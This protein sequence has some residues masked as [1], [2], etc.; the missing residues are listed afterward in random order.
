MENIPLRLRTTSE[1]NVGSWYQ[2]KS[3]EPKNKQALSLENA[4]VA[5]TFL[6]QVCLHE[7]IVRP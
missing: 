6:L 5:P 4:S 2:R 3:E 7:G 1:R